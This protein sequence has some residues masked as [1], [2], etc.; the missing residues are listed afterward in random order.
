MREREH[1]MDDTNCMAQIMY[2]LNFLFF[3][4]ATKFEEIYIGRG[5]FVFLGDKLH[6]LY[7]II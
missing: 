4:N 2:I 7:M 1:D 3:L 5:L 6:G